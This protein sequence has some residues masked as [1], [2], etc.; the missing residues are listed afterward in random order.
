LYQKCG[1]ATQRAPPCAT[2][3]AGRRLHDWGRPQRTGG[4]LGK[5]ELTELQI[6]VQQAAFAKFSCK[7]RPGIPKHCR[8]TFRK[9][10]LWFLYPAEKLVAQYNIGP[11]FTPPIVAKPNGPLGTL[12][13]PADVGGTNWPGGSLDPET[14]RLYIHSHTAVFNLQESKG[15]E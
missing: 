6:R 10:A 14:N 15:S 7:L 11:L 1:P 8:L 5:E 3:L 9:R 2:R 12:M 13:L 4:E